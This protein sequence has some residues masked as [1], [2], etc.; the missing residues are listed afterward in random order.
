[1]FESIIIRPNSYRNHP[2]DYGQLI[3]NLFFYKKTIAHIGRNEIKTLFS[4]AEVDVLEQLLKLPSLSIFFNNSHTAI[5]KNNNIRTVDPFGIADL[6]LEKELYQGA[7]EHSGD[8]FKSKKFSKKLSRLIKV[9][10]LPPNFS[11]TLNEQ[12][13]DEAYRNK[14]LIEIIND[15]FQNIGM[16]MEDLRFDLEYLNDNDFKVHTNI[17][18]GYTDQITEDDPILAIINTC[19]DLHVM[20]ENLSEISLPD[21]NSKMLR[22]RINSAIEKSDKSK[23]EIDVF[24]HYV[25]DESWALRE[26]I[27][28]KRIHVKAVL[29][30]LPKAEK[31]KDWLQELPNDANLINEYFQKVEEKTVLERFPLKPIRFYLVNT[32]TAI[33]SELPEGVGMSASIALNSF[34]TFLLDKLITKKW[35]PNQFINNDLRPFIKTK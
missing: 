13:K 22:L 16:K 28:S 23:K 14:V 2:L 10:Q 6:D 1:M 34:D 3:E 7:F 12:L 15:K 21:N 5:L 24:N 20:S 11:R 31:Y 33:L 4:L 30:L 18:F 27:N 8:A 9:H 35:K 17:N 19:D 29:N 25:Y 32:I 26:A